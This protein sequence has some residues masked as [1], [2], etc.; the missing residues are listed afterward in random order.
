MY[1]LSAMV[2]Y[3]SSYL[4]LEHLTCS[5]IISDRQRDWFQLKPNNTE[6]LP[7]I[8]VLAGLPLKDNKGLGMN[9]FLAG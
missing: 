3:Y 6:I 4:S 7:N 5:R 9:F 1:D 8:Q 2:S